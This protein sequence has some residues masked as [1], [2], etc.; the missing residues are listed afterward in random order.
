MLPPPSEALPKKP[1]KP[2]YFKHRYQNKILKQKCTID[3]SV[4][5]KFNK[6]EKNVL[7]NLFIK[8]PKSKVERP[9]RRQTVAHIKA[10][11]CKTSNLDL[12]RNFEISKPALTTDTDV[13]STPDANVETND[14]LNS[15]FI[16]S[17]LYFFIIANCMKINAA[18]FLNYFLCVLHIF[19]F[20]L[21]MFPYF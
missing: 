17:S 14:N 21:L 13:E 10:V 20:I 2:Q 9:L 8:E 7:S 3:K 16:L 4:L 11:N 18:L 1:N 15:T 12:E 6:M 19:L 5:N